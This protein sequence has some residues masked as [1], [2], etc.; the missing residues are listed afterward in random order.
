M[1]Y[2]LS[3]YHCPVM[4]YN[5][6]TT[7]KPSQSND[8]STSIPYSLPS[9]ASCDNRVPAA[10]CYSWSG[11]VP[12]YHDPGG[13]FW[14]HGPLGPDA[15]LSHHGATYYERRLLGGLLV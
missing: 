2:L 13:G 5:V 1:A 3:N 11:N 10:A 7:R 9:D 15:Q 4:L 14:L 8:T 12:G 6:L